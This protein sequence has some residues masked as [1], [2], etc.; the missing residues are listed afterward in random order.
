MQ[1]APVF[2]TR[3]HGTGILDPH[4]SS[5]CRKD[6]SDSAVV[7]KVPLW[8]SRVEISNRP[9]STWRVSS[10]AANGDA[11][12]PAGPELDTV[13]GLV[14]DRFTTGRPWDMGVTVERPIAP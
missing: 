12:L 6:G 5:F 3:G 8:N 13:A 14:A 7:S 1:H 2:G 10:V 4:L 11:R 9:L